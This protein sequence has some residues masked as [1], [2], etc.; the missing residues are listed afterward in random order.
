MGIEFSTFIKDY[1]FSKVSEKLMAAITESLEYTLFS[2][3]V[4]VVKV[5]V[6]QNFISTQTYW[7]LI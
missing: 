4:Q 2:E 7:H 5:P 1:D 3:K 6:P